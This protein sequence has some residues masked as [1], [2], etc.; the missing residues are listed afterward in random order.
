[1]ALRSR[2]S[3]EARKKRIEE[4]NEGVFKK[5]L[6][7]LLE[8]WN[9]LGNLTLAQVFAFFSRKKDEDE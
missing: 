5:L 4:A 3:R 7:P 9:A 1:M 8:F 6:R 2:S